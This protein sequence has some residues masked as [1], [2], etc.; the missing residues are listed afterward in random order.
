MGCAVRTTNNTSIKCQS[1]AS[2]QININ[3]TKSEISE[4]NGGV[5][6]PKF[7]QGSITTVGRCYLIIFC[8]VAL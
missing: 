6:Q 3:S 4:S 2:F 7:N 1:F 8:V 5:N